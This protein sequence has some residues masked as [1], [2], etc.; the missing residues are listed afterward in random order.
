MKYTL[1]QKNYSVI[2]VDID[3][4][5]G[6]ILE[7]GEIHD[8]RRIP[9]GICEQ[10]EI[11]NV[12]KFEE[13]WKSRS[14]PLSRQGLQQALRELN[15]NSP[16][17]LITKCLGLSLSDQYWIRPCDKEIIWEDI[18]FFDNDFSEDIGNILFGEKPSS[19]K[20]HMFSP[21]NAANGW[22]KKKWKIIDGKRCLVKAGD[23][24]QQQP[25]NEVI[26]TII[27]NKLGINHTEYK[28]GY[29]ERYLPVCVCEDFITRDTEL[30]PAA[31]ISLSLPFIEG[32]TKYEHF[33]RCCE[34]LEIPDFQKSLDEIMFLD[35]IIANED[36]HFGNFGVIR[37]V[38]SLRFIGFSPIY[39]SGT[40]LRY[41]SPE[42]L[43]EPNSDIASKPFRYF[44]NEQIEL[45]TDF[46]KFDLSK[47]KGIEKDIK[48]LFFDE[49]TFAY[50]KETRPKM[51]TDVLLERINMLDKIIQKGNCEHD[52]G[53]KKK[54]NK[55]NGFLGKD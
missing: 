49:R 27:S 1:M 28:L 32:E 8:F 16:E 3:P 55:G 52:T 43:I 34:Y 51:I 5:N 9:F 23:G 44:H 25:Y 45:V 50:M 7:L 39:D 46:S 20:L 47:L 30:I 29:T 24:F 48:N 19:D 36:R 15:I 41:D 17:E 38:D 33:C 6:R 37:D 31:F 12:Y 2:D 53:A 18:N 4:I 54:H 42:T 26:A 22:L 14:I 11:P 40:S 35:Y 13:W 21:D 10:N